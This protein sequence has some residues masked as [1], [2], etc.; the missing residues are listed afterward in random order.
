MLFISL[1]N[2]I[3]LVAPSQLQQTGSLVGAY[4]IQFPDRGLKPSPLHWE[5]GILAT[6]PPGKSPQFAT[7]SKVDQKCRGNISHLYIFFEKKKCGIE[8]SS[9]YKDGFLYITINSMKREEKVLTVE[10]L[11]W[12]CGITLENNLV[13]SPPS[14]KKKKITPKC[15]FLTAKD[16]LQCVKFCFASSFT[17]YIIQ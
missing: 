4:G 1:K 6:R 9:Y 11:T 3:Y 7:L 15:S 14:I 13:F 16:N 12:E 10:F 17:G 8:C 2:V 5:D